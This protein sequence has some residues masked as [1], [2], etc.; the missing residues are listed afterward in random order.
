MPEL[1]A[2]ARRV[3]RLRLE[4][5]DEGIWLPADADLLELLL[6]E[7]DYA[8]HPHAHEGVAPR[9]G[10]LLAAARTDA[11]QRRRTARA[12]RRRRR[13]ARRRPPPRRRPLVVRR[14]RRRRR[15]PARLLR[16]HAGVRVVGRPPRRRRPAPS[17]VQRLGRGLGPPDARRR[18]W[19]RGTA[20][21]GRRSRSPCTSPSASRRMLT[22]ADPTVLANLARVVHALAR[23]RAGRGDARLAP[24]RRPPRAR[25]PRVRRRRR[26]PA[27][28][29]DAAAAHF[30][31]LL[32][33]LS[34][35]DRAALVDAARAACRPSASTCGRPSARAATSP[36]TAAPGTPRRCG[37][38]PTSPP[39]LVFVVSSSGPLSV[40]WHG[41]RLD[42]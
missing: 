21:T 38:P 19:R 15:R 9:Y 25:P 5:D 34:Q 1:D 10:A 42:T 14:P 24:R 4:L 35:Y 36:R 22:G 37:S 6:A 18:A 29:P 3:E 33:A 16:P 41:R 32:N 17:C 13:P 28:R 23:R 31:P 20:S 7:L 40:F 11:P 30:A 2:R 39:P 26:H 27:A 8:R 12:R